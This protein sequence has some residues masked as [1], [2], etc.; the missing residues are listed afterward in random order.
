MPQLSPCSL[1]VWEEVGCVRLQEPF[2]FVTS[3]PTAINCFSV[4]FNH[5]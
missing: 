4:V 2:G 3:A 1:C 5:G